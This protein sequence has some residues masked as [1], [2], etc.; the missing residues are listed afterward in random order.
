[1]KPASTELINFLAANRKF[2]FADCYTITLRGD[3]VFRY[4]TTQRNITTIP[5]GG[6]TPV[7]FLA[8][9]LLVKG[10][11]YKASIG[12]DVDEQTIE[13][14]YK[15]SFTMNDLPM[16]VALRLGQW[17]G[18]SIR[19]DRY[20]LSSDNWTEVIGG[21]TLFTGKVSRVDR[22]G[23][24]QSSVQVVSD[25]V[26]LNQP[27]PRNMY[28]AGCGNTLFDG[29]CGLLKDNFDTQGE[30]EASSTVLTIN[31]ASAT[32]GYYDLGTVTFEGGA[33]DGISRTIR[34][35]TGT[36]LILSSPLP[37]VPQTGDD[38]VAYPGCDRTLSTCQNKF[39]N[40]DNYRGYPYIPTPETA[41]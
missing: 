34:R 12:T 9:Q 24:I 38:F 32:A 15:T 18:A 41:I 11:Q 23:I 27:M 7:T 5:V 22:I 36:A 39:S 13:L 10:L 30:V 33:N 25:M 3:H 26:L 6:D 14:V 4:T 8:G 2:H 19:R 28:Q 29:T 35:S 17:D 21:V 1:M 20:F 40:E 37:N 16:A 31:W